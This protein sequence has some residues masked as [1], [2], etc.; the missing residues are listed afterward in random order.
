MTDHVPH[1]HVCITC[2]ASRPLAPGDTPPGAH[3]H[4]A[5]ARLLTDAPSVILHDVSCLALCDRG[6]AAAIAMP[7]RWTYLLGGLEDH[8][9]GD[10]LT[11]AASYAASPT[12]ALMPSR[13]PAS[14]KAAMIGRVP[15]PENL[16]PENLVPETLV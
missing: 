7:G 12:G 2:R 9:A 15:A 3:L 6:C 14:L 16:V 8:M 13:R 10:L 5:I 4:A 11:Y 1:L